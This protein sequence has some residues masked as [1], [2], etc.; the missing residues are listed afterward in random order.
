MRRLFEGGVYSK[1]YGIYKSLLVAV[2]QIS[3][4]D[5]KTVTSAISEVLKTMS[6]RKD[7]ITYRRMNDHVLKP[8]AS[9]TPDNSRHTDFCSDSDQDTDH[10]SDT[11]MLDV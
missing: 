7:A 4:S 3:Q 9:P 6:H 2:V 8:S 10:S 1:K 5:Q 11:V